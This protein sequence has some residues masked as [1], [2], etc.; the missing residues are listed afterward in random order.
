MLKLVHTPR[1]WELQ[2]R[3]LSVGGSHW[4]S[5]AAIACQEKNGVAN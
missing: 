1:R 3:H 5:A 4:Q 2:A